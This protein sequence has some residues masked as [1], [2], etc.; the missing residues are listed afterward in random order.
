MA[1]SGR[2][3]MAAVVAGVVAGGAGAFALLGATAS[4]AFANTSPYEIYCPGTPVG[5]IVMNDVVTNGTISPASPASGQQ[6]SLNGY[7][8][9]VVLPSSIA[10]AAAALGNS[11]IVGTAVL[12]V[13]ATGATP[14]AVSAGSLPINAPLPSPVPSSGVT[15]NLPASPGTVGPFTASGSTISL[16]VDPAISLTVTVSGSNLNLTCTPYPN[17]TAPSGITSSAPSGSKASPVIATATAGGGGAPATTAAPTATTAPSTPAPS[18]LASTGPGPHLWLV[19]VIGFVVLYLGSVALALVE[20]PR[21]LLRR[22]LHVIRPS[23]PLPPDTGTEL[24]VATLAAQS[25]LSAQPVTT[26]DSARAG[27]A[28]PKA[29]GSQGL[30]FDGWEPTD[31]R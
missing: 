17:N 29:D 19:A 10:S 4:P 22:A 23:T 24:G 9:V 13:D 7:Q 18:T 2:K 6:F 14:A 16:T 3:R 21:S 12:K 25:A 8:S 26:V 20:R 30:W 15:L 1:R 5:N 27:P 31:R 28:Y 11:A